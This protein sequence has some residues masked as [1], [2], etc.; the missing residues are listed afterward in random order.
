M[1]NVCECWAVAMG[2]VCECWAVA[3]GI[4]CECWA[5]AIVKYRGLYSSCNFTHL[6]KRNI[7]EVIKN[8]NSLEF[9]DSRPESTD[10]AGSIIDVIVLDNDMTPSS[11]KATTFSVPDP[12]LLGVPKN[13]SEGMASRSSISSR[14]SYN[15][16][17]KFGAYRSEYIVKSQLM[18]G[19]RCVDSV[20]PFF[21][22]TE[23]I[24]REPSPSSSNSTL[25]QEHH[26]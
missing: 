17:W 8:A 12:T 2:N 21:I 10:E 24:E 4:V 1:G 11:V 16:V 13:I 23:K 15:L 20:G 7:K 3:M 14:T 6:I 9:A 25:L 19:A 5:V 18:D 26:T 22:M